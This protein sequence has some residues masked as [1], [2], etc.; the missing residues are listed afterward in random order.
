[1]TTRYWIGVVSQSHVIKGVNGGFAQLCHGKCAPLKRMNV[2]DWLIYYS[3][4]TDMDSGTSLQKFTAVG[5]VLGEFVYS[6]KMSDDFI[7]FRRDITYL[8]CNSV[9]IALLIHRLSFIKDP[10]KWGYPFRYG[11]IE[12]T[13]VDFDIIAQAMMVNFNEKI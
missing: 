8:K 12:I 6:F 9:S 4:K 13:K 5:Q 10:K 11:H 1:M 3:P 2:G 7:P